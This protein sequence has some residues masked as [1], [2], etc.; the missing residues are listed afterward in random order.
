M[1]SPR[2]EILTQLYSGPAQAKSEGLGSPFLLN[3]GNNNLPTGN[4][5]TP[6]QSAGSE[7]LQPQITLS[8]INAA[9]IHPSPNPPVNPPPSNVMNP[10]LNLQ[11]Q[12]LVEQKQLTQHL[13]GLPPGAAMQNPNP[14]P[15]PGPAGLFSTPGIDVG[16]MNNMGGEGSTPRQPTPHWTGILKWISDGGRQE[17]KCVV[18]LTNAVTVHKAY[19]SLFGLKLKSS[20]HRLSSPSQACKYMAKHHDTS[21]CWKVLYG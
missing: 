1:L 12:K 6:H 15:P 18:S 9:G 13:G 19:V 8:T 5:P 11:M 7:L 17:M 14:N 21:A 10:A 4:V 16:G 3:A 20:P 2:F